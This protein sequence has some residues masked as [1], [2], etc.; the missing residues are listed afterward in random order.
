[1]NTS[2]KFKYNFRKYPVIRAF[3]LLGI[4][5][6]I[7]GTVFFINKQ[8][9][10]IPEIESID[11]PVG[12]PGDVIVISGKNF[13]DV[14]DMSYVEFS[15]AKLTASSYISW[16]EDKIKIVLPANVQDG[17]VVVGTK[18]LRS[19]PSLFANEVNIP[20]PVTNS[21]V[22]TK[23]VITE[24]T[25]SKVSV[26][27][28]LVITGNNFGD[29]RNQSKVL[30]T[31]DY[32][33]KIA[34][35]EYKN[36]SMFT[37]NMISAN[38][39]NF[40][41]VSWS[42]TEIKVYI[43]DGACSGVIVV[44]KELE[45]SDPYNITITQDAGSKN[46]I[47][48]KIYLLQYTVDIADVV[49]TD[50]AT[51]TLRSPVP[52]IYSAQPTLEI[53][54]VSPEPVLT[55]Y[56]HDMIQQISKSKSNLPKTVASQSF[57]LPVYEIQSNIVPERI[58][59][60]RET[61]E[62]LYAMF[63]ESDELVPSDDE[64]I[65]ELSTNIAGKEKNPYK[66]AKLIYDYMCDNYKVDEKYRKNDS[67]PLDLL[68]RGR[69][70]SY[71]FAVIYTALLRSAGIPAITDAGILVCQDMMT[72]PHWWCEFYLQDFGWLPV[73]PAIGA[74][75]SYRVWQEGDEVN[76]REYNFGNLDSH[77]IAFSR[78]WNQLRPFSQ[79]N[80]IVQQPRSFALQSIWEE[81]SSNIVKY[82]SFWTVPV[83]KGVY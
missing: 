38:D 72:Q 67:N 20:I 6:L 19:K 42:N 40:D 71:D 17:L 35:A 56:Q 41:Y 28:L 33:K 21:R 62:A 59:Q 68:R 39:D 11:P 15:G 60:Y 77:H 12:A 23:P 66:K 48:K 1:M 24:I 49:T 37:E 80:K 63:T 36:V 53:T 46:Y 75:L 32:N 76:V 74:G 7:L 10:P 5:A 34:E 44:D 3:I 83:V 57:V 14:R 54:E 31:I 25:K 50:T 22:I 64:K 26:G 18:N 70:D 4:I 13:G 8:R 65:V 43:P 78:G 73:D 2:G 79:D 27:D 30:F 16:S 52:A 47:N 82:S 45:K 58:G 9:T 61:N 81:A 69:G 55:N 29:V 51:I